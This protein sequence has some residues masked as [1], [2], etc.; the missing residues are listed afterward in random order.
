MSTQ[1]PV[2]RRTLIDRVRDS[3]SMLMREV[4]KFGVVGLTAFVID[5]GLFNILMYA[6]GEGPLADK[7]L[8]A[9]ALSVMAATTFAYFGNRY[10]TFRHRGRTNMGREYILFFLLNGVAMLI[11]VGCLWFSHYLLGLTSPLADNISANVIGLALGTL[12]RFWS[13]RRW[14]F[15]AIPADDPAEAELAERDAA[16]PI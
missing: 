15:P 16:T 4:A 10:W 1:A 5:V 6:G 3:L 9:K 2:E 14:V 12:F 13:Y 8:T 11:S 7:P